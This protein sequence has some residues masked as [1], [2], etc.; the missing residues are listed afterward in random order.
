MYY[1]HYLHDS[2]SMFRFLHGMVR[3]LQ[4]KFRFLHDMIC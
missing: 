4:T 1:V 2:V 3:F